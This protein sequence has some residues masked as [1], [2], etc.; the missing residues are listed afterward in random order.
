MFLFFQFRFFQFRLINHFINKQVFNTFQVPS[1]TLK[2][3][4]FICMLFANVELSPAFLLVH[5][6]SYCCS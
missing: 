3:F 5:R 2:T 4:M 6:L 1:L